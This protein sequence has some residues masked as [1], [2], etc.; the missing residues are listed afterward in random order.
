M[1]TIVRPLAHPM[2]RLAGGQI[3]ANYQAGSWV[4]GAEA[5]ACVSA[6]GLRSGSL[7]Q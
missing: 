4:V 6:L 2:D 1:K 7:E 5:D 3:G